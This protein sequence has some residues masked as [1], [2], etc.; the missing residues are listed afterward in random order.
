MKQQVLLTNEK[1]KALDF[2]AS[3]LLNFKCVQYDLLHELVTEK[4]DTD[5]DH[6]INELITKK[7]VDLKHG[8]LMILNET[9]LK[10]YCFGAQLAVAFKDH[11]LAA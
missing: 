2:I 7:A 11:C 4:F 8:G 6:L 5:P 9:V 1:I 3:R 10:Q